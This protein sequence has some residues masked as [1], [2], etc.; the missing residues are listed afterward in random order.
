M[1]AT[2]RTRGRRRTILAV[3]AL[4][5]L[6][7]CAGGDLH[8]MKSYTNRQLPRPDEIY[9]YPFAADFG[10]T[11]T[12]SGLLSRLESS[13]DPAT[14][15]HAIQQEALQVRDAVT[16]EIVKRLRDGGLPAVRATAT[17]PAGRNVLIVNGAFR[18]VSAGNRTR[19]LVIG[20]GTGKSDVET[21]VRLWYQPADGTP[22]LVRRYDASAEGGKEPGIA[23]TAGIGA[24][25]GHLGTS[26]GIGAGAHAAT[27]TLRDSVNDDAKRVADTIAKEIGDFGHAQGWTA[28]GAP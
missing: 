11:S 1:T 8:D 26:L 27:E 16:D 14:T 7:G 15:R 10:D 28:A 23:E 21:D 25:I 13:G 2:N 12:D 6:G 5:A 9:V 22:E 18:K 19:R 24:A 3:C 20:L 4:L 17:P